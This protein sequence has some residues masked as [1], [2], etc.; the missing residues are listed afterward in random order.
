MHPLRHVVHRG[1]VRPSVLGRHRVVQRFYHLVRQHE[2]QSHVR[3]EQACL[4]TLGDLKHHDQCGAQ[5]NVALCAHSRKD[6]RC[7]QHEVDH[8]GVRSYDRQTI[9]H[10]GV[11]MIFHHVGQKA[12][13]HAGRRIFRRDLQ[14]A[15]R[16]VAQKACHR[17]VR[18]ACHHVGQSFARHDRQTVC[19]RVVRRGVIHDL[20]N[21]HRSGPNCDRY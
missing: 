3:G 19:L 7:V 20:H 1:E 18:R 11:H 17:E 21:H 15:Y 5:T 8:H 10:H 6:C 16:H 2:A 9:F 4:H 14:T 13:R 12:D